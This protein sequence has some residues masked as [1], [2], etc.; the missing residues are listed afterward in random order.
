MGTPR[1][2]KRAVSA[3]MQITEVTRIWSPDF[4]DNTYER[5]KEL[6][7]STG[8]ITPTTAE[9]RIGEAT[10]FRSPDFGDNTYER[11]KDLSS[12]VGTVASAEKLDVW[13]TRRDRPEVQVSRR[14]C[15]RIARHG[16]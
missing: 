8:S 12:D 3:Q 15:M 14:A 10:S 4:G 13:I 9:G 6:S 5:R 2:Y 1:V 16:R 7:S 11:R